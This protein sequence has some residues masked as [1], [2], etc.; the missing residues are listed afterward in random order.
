VALTYG[1]SSADFTS[2]TT[3]RLR[4]GVPVWFWRTRTGGE[5]YT[6]VLAALAGMLNG[7]GSAVS[8][9]GVG[10][11]AVQ[12]PDDFTGELYV[13][14]VIRNDDG[15]VDTAATAAGPRVR[16]V[17]PAGAGGGGTVDTS[18][19]ATDA[20]LAALATDVADRALQADLIALATSA[21][22][23]T[24]PEQVQD[25][26]AAMVVAGANVT[27]S[28]DDATGT[29]TITAV[30]GGTTDP[31]VV[32]DAI[33]GAL[34]AGAGININYNDAA[35]TITITATGPDA[36]T[37]ASD[38]AF[39]TAYAPAGDYAAAADLIGVEVDPDNPGVV[40]FV[41][42]AGAGA[43][44]GGG[45]G[46]SSNPATL[47]A[48]TYTGDHVLEVGD[49]AR[50][51]VMDGSGDSAVLVP[52]D[53]AAALPVGAEIP[54]LRTG[55]GSVRVAPEKINL[56]PNGAVATT[57]AP[58][59]ARNGTIT[60]VTG[61][62][63][64]G[65]AVARATSTGSSGSFGV[66]AGTIALAG[67]GLGIGD[68]VSA[69]L[70]VNGQ[71]PTRLALRFQ[72]DTT[73]ITQAFST[74]VTGAG[75]ARVDGAVIPAGTTGILIFTEGTATATGQTIDHYGLTVTPGS[76]SLTDHFDGDSADGE[77]A[78]DP[79][80]SASYSAV[81]AGGTPALAR[82]QRAT[83]RKVAAGSWVLA[84]TA[85]TD[86]VRTSDTLTF[87][88]DNGQNGMVAPSA[89]YAGPATLPLTSGRTLLARVAPSRAMSVSSIAFRVT[90]ASATSDPVSV[91]L[92]SADGVRLSTSGAVTPGVNTTGTKVVAL[93]PVV[94]APGSV[95]YAALSSASTATIQGT[96]VVA[97]AFGTALPALESGYV[98][99]HP[100]G[101][102]ITTPT[103]TDVAPL[104]F[105]REA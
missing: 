59:T 11:L 43:G 23:K 1:D 33:G 2:D 12:V 79:G 17:P 86:V 21:E 69:R 83:L 56:H 48:N 81:L 95:Y 98:A 49:L 94:L 58:F 45:G 68:K 55:A 46:G 31:E 39:T 82:Y 34:V 27:K 105:L 44:L 3:G 28:Y 51:I 75:V 14:A 103:P 76:T 77:W 104:L 47:T 38:P 22:G 24:T 89:G 78:G 73:T 100:V 25:I 35:D 5:Q 42:G 29:L 72:R 9:A 92:F 101:A 60:R 88:R 67:T 41:P 96:E 74:Y 19:L 71:V 13:S 7:D 85:P 8:S 84:N 15:T 62:A 70:G 40:R 52:H 61:A 53:A 64:G 54:L 32:R 36:T 30:G 97:D 63:P 10:S 102:T 50:L 16:L 26:V 20:E 57:L 65:G 91:A 87:D 99:A 37:L 4:P 18:G 90:T 66:F 6:G 93:L 80:A